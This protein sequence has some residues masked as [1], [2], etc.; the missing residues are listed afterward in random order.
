MNTIINDEINPI[1]IYL[2][3]DPDKFFLFRMRSPYSCEDE[4][5]VL[6][7]D[8]VCGRTFT[9]VIDHEFYFESIYAVSI[10]QQDDYANVDPANAEFKNQISFNVKKRRHCEL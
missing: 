2:D 5:M 1:F 3:A 4:Y 7:P 10:Y 6:V 9:F 8:G